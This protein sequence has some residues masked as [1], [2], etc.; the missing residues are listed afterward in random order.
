MPLTVLPYTSQKLTAV[1]PLNCGCPVLPATSMCVVQ[2]ADIC[3]R[4]NSH[5]VQKRSRLQT[6]QKIATDDTSRNLTANVYQELSAVVTI[7]H[8]ATR[9]ER[10]EL[11][12]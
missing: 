10:K 1:V 5:I 12:A 4:D 6:Q 7:T 3:M 8:S 11:S 2:F 9:K